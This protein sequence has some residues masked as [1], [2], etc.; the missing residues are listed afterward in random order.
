M[1]SAAVQAGTPATTPSWPRRITS[2]ATTAL[3]VAAVAVFVF[4][5]IGPRILGYQTVTMLTGSMS[6]GINPGDVVVSMPAAVS[7]LA[8]GDIITYHIPVEDQRVETHRIV[9]RTV[10]EDGRTEVRTKGDA[11]SH[12]DPWLAT[13]QGQTVYRHAATIPHLG[14]AIRALR[15]PAVSMT[16]MYAV[17]GLLVAGVLASIW[18]K[19]TTDTAAAKAHGRRRKTK[20]A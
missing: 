17:P 15:A 5:A 8:I 2:W 18:R 1:S 13:L 7:E 12:A 10:T 4:L 20:A 3:I 14:T 6:P 16:L 9:E 11:N 19:D